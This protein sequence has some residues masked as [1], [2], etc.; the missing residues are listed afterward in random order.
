MKEKE[1]A[2]ENKC[3]NLYFR[4]YRQSQDGATIQEESEEESADWRSTVDTISVLIHCT[5]YIIQC[6]LYIVY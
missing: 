1:E 5:W 6:T 4:L 3:N 2:E